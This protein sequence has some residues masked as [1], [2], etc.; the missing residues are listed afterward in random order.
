MILKAKFDPWTDYSTIS[1]VP[2]S[3]LDLVKLFSTLLYP[4]NFSINYIDSKMNIRSIDNDHKYKEA[5]IDCLS[6]NLFHLKLMI[7]VYKENR[8]AHFERSNKKRNSL[9]SKSEVII[10]ES[11]SDRSEGFSTDSECGKGK[12][13]RLRKDKSVL[14]F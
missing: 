10:E 8:V 6:N 11:C 1:E 12:K 13:K 9:V 4:N 14:C 5:L 7:N 3:F 2:N